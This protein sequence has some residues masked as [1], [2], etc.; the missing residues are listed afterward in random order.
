MPFPEINF[1]VICYKHAVAHYTF[2]VNYCTPAVARYTL[3][4]KCYTFAVSHYMEL[5]PL[6]G[7]KS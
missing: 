4:V 2:P 7:H 5:L 6:G 1:A 3:A